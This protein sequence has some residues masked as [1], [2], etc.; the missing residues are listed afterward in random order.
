MKCKTMVNTALAT[1][2]FSL[3]LANVAFSHQNKSGDESKSTP[4]AVPLAK[5]SP[6]QPETKRRGITIDPE[7]AA[8]Y[9]EASKPSF[10]AMR[11]AELLFR[12]HDLTGA[13][14]AA[15]ESMRLAWEAGAGDVG[16]S[17]NLIRKIRMQQGKYQE[18]LE[19]IGA[20]WQQGADSSLDLDVALCYVRL[21]NTTKARQFYSDENTLRYASSLT[22][23]DLPGTRNRK[24][25]E[26]SILIARGIDKFFRATGE[27]EALADFD[28][29]LTLAP[30]NGLAAYYAA[31]SLVVL[32]RRTEAT[33]Y[34]IKAAQNGHGTFVKQ[35]RRWIPG[36]VLS[37]MDA[38]TPAQ[39]AQKLPQNLP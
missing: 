15:K 13:E 24:M 5:P 9:Q 19:W 18:A 16:S 10:E 30:Q 34:F 31:Q 39:P 33:P 28:A 23:Q 7:A 1:C 20:D 36:D 14:N 32:G 6:A 21:G 22:V 4:P 25:L 3:S 26:A 38:Q 35:A 11:Q 29:A 27:K 17:R 12:K 37:K 8:R 2:A